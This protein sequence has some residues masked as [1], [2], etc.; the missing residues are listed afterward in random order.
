MELLVFPIILQTC[1]IDYF[2][3]II[4]RQEPYAC[5]TNK[6]NSNNNYKKFLFRRQGFG[7][8][9]E[10]IGLKDL[11]TLI[12]EKILNKINGYKLFDL[13]PTGSLA[14]FKFIIFVVSLTY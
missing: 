6:N 10:I 13:K 4:L 12:S 1:P 3:Y 14:N 11:C 8:R 9:V 7:A 5:A 2:S